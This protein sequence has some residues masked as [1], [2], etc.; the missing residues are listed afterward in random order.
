MTGGLAICSFFMLH[1]PPAAKYAK[2]YRLSSKWK[3][4]PVLGAIVSAG[5]GTWRY[6]KSIWPHIDVPYAGIFFSILIFT[7]ELGGTVI[8]S[9]VLAVR[10]FANMFAG[11]MVLAMLLLFI[12]QVGK[13]G[14]TF[15]WP[16]VTIS[17]VLGV[18]ALS[19]LELFVGFL[20]AYV[21]TFLTALFMGMSLHPEH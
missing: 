9:G 14:F 5:V 16:V 15:L 13:N 2:A 7:I 19:L 8:K 11:H 21:F 10:L 17:S 3:D 4:K 18:V 12:F 1:V 20:Q 6:L